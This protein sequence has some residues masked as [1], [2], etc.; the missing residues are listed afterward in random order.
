MRDHTAAGYYS[1]DAVAP[2]NTSRSGLPLSPG[3][4]ATLPHEWDGRP[5]THQADHS[6]AIGKWQL[7][8]GQPLRDEVAPVVNGLGVGFSVCSGVRNQP[9]V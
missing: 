4:Y 8:R 5:P 9:L 2:S 6:S 3:V 7:V 1:T